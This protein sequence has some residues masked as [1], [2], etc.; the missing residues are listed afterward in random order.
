M[1]TQPEMDIIAEME[2]EDTTAMTYRV[3]S[4]ADA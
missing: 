2:A 1:L 3:D 4:D